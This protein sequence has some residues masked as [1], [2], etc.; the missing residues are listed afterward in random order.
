MPKVSIIIPALNEARSL[1]AL[2]RSIATQSFKDFEVVLADA[3]STDETAAIAK[4]FG[5]RVVTGGLPSVGRN[6]GAVAAQGEYLLFLDA[7]VILGRHF[8]REMVT[9]FE[10]KKVDVASCGIVPLSDKLVDVILHGVANAYISVTQYFYPHAPGF[11]ILIKKSLHEQINGFD[12]ALTLAEDHDYVKRA[13]ELGKFRI[14]KTPKIFVSV[15]RF[16]SDGRL[17]VSA[18]YVLCEMYR[19]MLGEVKTNAF[20][21]KFG[22]HKVEK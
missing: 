20:K 7:D 13:R 4:E 1:R 10:A 3:G 22:H 11:C 14:L 6:A 2:L 17:N 18:K 19:M 16:E 9:E 21:Y 8:L 5:V 12:T 15:R